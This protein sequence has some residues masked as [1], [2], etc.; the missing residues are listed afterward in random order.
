MF[1]FFICGKD[2][3]TSIKINFLTDRAI[4]RP[5]SSIKGWRIVEVFLGVICSRS[6]RIWIIVWNQLHHKLFFLLHG[7]MLLTVNN[8]VCWPLKLLRVLT[9][10]NV[11]WSVSQDWL[12]SGK[13]AKHFFK[14]YK[15][16]LWLHFVARPVKSTVPNNKSQLVN[17]SYVSLPLSSLFS[18]YMGK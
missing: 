18:F 4:F 15:W 16:S 9:Q 7:K 13:A 11:I 5:L 2:A 10:L 17:G 12:K 14:S 8:L 6:Q 3:L 1:R